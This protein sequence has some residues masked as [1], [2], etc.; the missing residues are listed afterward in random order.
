M[1]AI[2]LEA[3]GLSVLRAN[4][5][6]FYSSLKRRM[7]KPIST[8]YIFDPVKIYVTCSLSCDSLSIFRL[9]VYSN[10]KSFFLS[11]ELIF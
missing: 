4:D 7:L 2:N 5:E 8:E 1:Y 6:I 10:G 9:L 11:F 3:I